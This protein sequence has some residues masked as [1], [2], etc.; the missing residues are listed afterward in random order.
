MFDTLEK[1]FDLG[2]RPHLGSAKPDTP[3]TSQ[4]NGTMIARI[5]RDA[6]V[7]HAIW[8]LYDTRKA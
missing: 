4:T 2:V 8:T 7:G 6:K 3:S 5:H 1:I